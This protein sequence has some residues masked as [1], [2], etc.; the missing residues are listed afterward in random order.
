M[1]TG[2]EFQ[3]IIADKLD[4][5]A[6]ILWINLM[7]DEGRCERFLRQ[8]FVESTPKFE[9][10]TWNANTGASWNE[11]LKDPTPAIFSAASMTQKYA[12]IIFHDLHLMLNSQVNFQLRRAI[13]ELCKNNQ[14]VN[15]TRAHPFIILAD[16]P[17]PH[18]DIKDYCDVIDYDLPTHQELIDDVFNHSQKSLRQQSD[19]ANAAECSD[20]LRDRIVEKL[21]GLSAEEAQRIFNY[22]IMCASGINEHIFAIIANEKAKSI[23]K[24]GGLKFVAYD[25][26]RD[27][28]SIAGFEV[29]LEFVHKRKWSYTRHAQSEGIPR[30]R[31]IAIVGPPGTGKTMMAMSI[32]KILGLDLIMM[33]IGSMY[34]SLVGSSEKRIRQALGVVA[35][36]PNCVLM[37]DKAC[38]ALSSGLVTSQVAAL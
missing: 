26:I 35:A 13:A 38:R 23:A 3:Q 36:M 4:S 19:D 17:T 37:V 1:P 2:Q 30:P 14:L 15:E 21:L 7:G 22:A 12:A 11:K 33:D 27:E 6:N 9:V 16:N 24:I 25:S 32:A 20:E 10:C 18:P 31:G 28:S 34:D 29:C 8:V 5:G